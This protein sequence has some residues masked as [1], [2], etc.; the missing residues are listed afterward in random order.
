MLGST[1]S[2]FSKD[3]LGERKIRTLLAS[4]YLA[5]SVSLL[6]RLPRDAFLQGFNTELSLSTTCLINSLCPTR[7]RILK[8]AG[9]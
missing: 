8:A 4:C 6:P 7:P 5:C 3:L 2:E 1:V 9:L